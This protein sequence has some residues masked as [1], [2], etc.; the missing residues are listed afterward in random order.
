MSNMA[1]YIEIIQAWSLLLYITKHA[2]TSYTAALANNKNSVGKSSSNPIKIAKSLC[3][4]TIHGV[5]QAKQG[6]EKKEAEAKCLYNE[7]GHTG[8]RKIIGRNN[9]K[10]KHGTTEK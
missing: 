6:E 1:W 7:H 8:S 5:L 10:E 3:S 2:C 9:H 4:Q